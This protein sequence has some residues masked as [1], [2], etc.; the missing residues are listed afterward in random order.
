MIEKHMKSKTFASIV[1]ETSG[2]LKGEWWRCLCLGCPAT[3]S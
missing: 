1:S 2:M 3:S